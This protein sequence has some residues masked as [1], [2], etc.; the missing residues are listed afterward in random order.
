MTDVVKC[1][2]C[3]IVIDELLSYIQNKISI[4][5][6]VPLVKI[7]VSAFTSKKISNSKS[8]LFSAVPADRRQI[9]RKRKGKESIWMT[10]LV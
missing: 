1:N 2:V 8:L 4:M 7:C 3:N 10:F 5:D 6:E 9:Q